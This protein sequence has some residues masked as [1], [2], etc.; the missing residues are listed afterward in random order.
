MSIKD[1]KGDPWLNIDEKYPV[2]S[3]VKGKAVGVVEYGVFV[4][5]EP[6]LEGLLH[7]SEMSWDKKMRNPPSSYRKATCSIFRS[8]TST[9][10]RNGS[11]LG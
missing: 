6:G 3:R 10:R 11:P 1:L 9:R 7:V 5:L 8:S 4:E 2:G